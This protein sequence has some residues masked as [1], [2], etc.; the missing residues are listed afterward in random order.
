MHNDSVKRELKRPEWLP[1]GWFINFDL[2]VTLKRHGPQTRSHHSRRCVRVCG[3][4]IGKANR[5]NWRMCL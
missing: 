3:Y 4:A 1:Q 2:C 5:Q